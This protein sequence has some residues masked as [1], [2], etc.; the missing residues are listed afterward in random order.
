MWRSGSSYEE[1]RLEGSGK[2]AHRGMCRVGDAVDENKRISQSRNMSHVALGSLQ[3]EPIVLGSLQHDP[4]C[5]PIGPVHVDAWE[6]IVLRTIESSS[7][8]TSAEAIVER[9]VVSRLSASVFLYMFLKRDNNGVCLV[10][11]ITRGS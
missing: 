4:C 3:H 2:R 10:N 8:P 11:K 6:R 5:K 9:R 1:I 7:D